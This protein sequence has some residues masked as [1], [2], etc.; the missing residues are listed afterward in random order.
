MESFWGQTAAA[1]KWRGGKKRVRAEDK[2]GGS[3]GR[4][5]KKTMISCRAAATEREYEAALIITHSLD[6]VFLRP[7]TSEVTSRDK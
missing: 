5:S 2:G 6:F 7:F 1:G 3:R 4:T